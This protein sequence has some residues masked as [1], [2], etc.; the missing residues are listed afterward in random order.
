MKPFIPND[1]FDVGSLHAC[2]EYALENLNTFDE[3]YFSQL[4]AKTFQLFYHYRQGDTLPKEVCR[5]ILV[6]TLYS[7]AGTCTPFSPEDI[8][9]SV[10]KELVSQLVCGFKAVKNPDTGRRSPA[11]E[12]L[13]V[14]YQNE[15]YQI[16]AQSFDFTPIKNK[17]SV[18][19]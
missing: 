17:N 13:A 2:W 4:A 15:F 10:A 1:K 7:E 8:S 3:S 14:S 11:G 18:R 16:E 5:L 9:Q 6:M 12:W 19:L